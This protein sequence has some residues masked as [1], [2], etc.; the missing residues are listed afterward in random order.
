MLQILSD[1]R[2]SFSV[3]FAEYVKVARMGPAPDGRL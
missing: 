3:S 2:W 1:E